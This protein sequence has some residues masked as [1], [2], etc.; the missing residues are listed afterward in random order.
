MAAGGAGHRVASLTRCLDRVILLEC[1][2]LEPGTQFGVVVSGKRSEEATAIPSR[3]KYTTSRIGSGGR[4]NA[5][6][7]YTK[8]LSRK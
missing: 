7:R 8:S 4:A 5:K 2:G 1:Y 6:A 3:R